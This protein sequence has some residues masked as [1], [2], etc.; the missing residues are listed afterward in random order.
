M[1]L[2]EAIADEC[3]LGNRKF[4]LLIDDAHEMNGDSLELMEGELDGNGKKALDLA[5]KIVGAVQKAEKQQLMPALKNA[6]KAQLSA[7]VQVKADCF[8][9]GESYNKTCEELCFQVAF[10]VA[11]LIQAI[12]EVHPNEE[13]KTEIEGIFSRLVIYE[14]GEVPGF[15]NAAYAVGK[16]ILAII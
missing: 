2:Q 13:K 1:K 4:C 8:T 14:R 16:E 9:L 5:D 7:F 6:I 11:E 15:E 3:K 12:I 10:V